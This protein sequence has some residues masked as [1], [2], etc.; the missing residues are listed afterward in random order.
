MK[1]IILKSKSS[2]ILTTLKVIG[3]CGVFIM[4]E[5]CYGSPKSTWAPKHDTKQ[6]NNKEVKGTVNTEVASVSQKGH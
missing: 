6:K 3:V 1:R 5:A 4:F 2:L